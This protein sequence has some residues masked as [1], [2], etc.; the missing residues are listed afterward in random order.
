L[1]ILLV[2]AIAITQLLT[3]SAPRRRELKQQLAA[4]EERPP[5]DIHALVREEV[6]DLGIERVPGSDGLDPEVLLRV[7]RRD[8]AIHQNC[9]DGIVHY[10]VRPGTDPGVAHDGDV[11]LVCADIDDAL[12]GWEEPLIP[13]E[14][15]DPTELLALD[16]EAVT[17][18]TDAPEPEPPAGP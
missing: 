8:E 7:W 4:V 9:I 12:P 2:G 15:P 5:I 10:Q 3:R 1:F 17:T 18:E 13:H 11:R 6:A 14:G 16:A